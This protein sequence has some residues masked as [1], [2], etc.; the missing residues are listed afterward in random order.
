MQTNPL[1]Q[2]K[3]S[4]TTLNAEILLNAPV[5]EVW[6][7]VG[8]NFD[9][10]MRYSTDVANS[11]YLRQADGMLGSRRRS[12]MHNGRTLDV[13]ITAWEDEVHVQW[14]IVK[15]HIP[16]LKSGV[17]RYILIAHGSQTRLVLDGYFKTMFFLLNPI[18]KMRFKSVV[19][20]DLAGIKHLVENGKTAHSENVNDTLAQ[21]RKQVVFR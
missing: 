16:I 2:G 13:E 4:A 20:D 14:E 19:A 6:D 5:S 18:A 17:S 12:E 8:A 3:P 9:K 1:T 21:Y 10:I 7:V 15:P 11:Y